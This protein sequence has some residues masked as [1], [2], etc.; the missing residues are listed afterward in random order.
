MG[1]IRKQLPF[2]LGSG[3]Q[4]RPPPF[5]IKMLRAAKPPFRGDFA[6][7]KTLVQRKSAAGQK[8]GW[9]VRLYLF[10]IS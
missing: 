8:A 7:G 1:T 2:V 4:R 6:W 10:E 9:V 5:G 3:R